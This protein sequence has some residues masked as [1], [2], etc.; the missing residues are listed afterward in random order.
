MPIVTV[1]NQYLTFFPPQNLTTS[2]VLTTNWLLKPHESGFP[3]ELA[4]KA[5]DNCNGL[6]V[7]KSLEKKSKLRVTYISNIGDNEELYFL[8]RIISA[9]N[10]MSSIQRTIYCGKTDI[11]YLKQ[12]S[13]EGIEFVLREEQQQLE[14][15]V[16]L[17]FGSSAIHFLKS[18][19]PVIIVGTYGL[20]GHITPENFEFLLKKGFM[21]RPGGAYNEEIPIE[22]LAEEILEVQY[23][24][25]LL[26]QNKQIQALIK[27]KQIPDYDTLYNQLE[28]FSIEYWISD[29]KRRWQL[30]MQLASNIQIL[31]NGKKTFLVRQHINDVMASFNEV[32]AL[33]FKY[34]LEKRSSKEAYNK[35]AIPIK[36]FWLM[37]SV[38]W[39]K[40]IIILYAKS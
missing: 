24:R 12:I 15:E 30:D 6:Q 38:L 2:F 17:C 32:E 4:Y 18:G 23:S 36:D 39:D 33:F 27:K 1:Q 19:L 22:L 28:S 21:G 9:F 8:M 7:K 10:K 14:T 25:I 35:A 20:G 26:N 3:E 11:E 16:I 40:K 37:V 5:Y 31:T 29:I 34:L 13:N